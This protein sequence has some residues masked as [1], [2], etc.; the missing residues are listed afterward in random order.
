MVKLKQFVPMNCLSV[1]DHF[2]RLALEG[3]IMPEFHR[4]FLRV[5][6]LVREPLKGFFSYI[7][8]RELAK[9]R[10]ICHNLCSGNY[11]TLR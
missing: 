1:F 5:L 10:E 7:D 11:Q 3:L 8:F 4:Y 6:I 9:I 2:M